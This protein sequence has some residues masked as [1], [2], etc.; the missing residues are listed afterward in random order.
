MSLAKNSTNPLDLPEIRTAVG[1]YLDDPG[2]VQCLQVCRSWYASFLPFVWST[3]LIM[4]DDYNPPIEALSRHSGFVKKLTF[5]SDVWQEYGSI[6]CPHLVSLAIYCGENPAPVIITQYE[7]LR[8]L[9]IYGMSCDPSQFSTFKTTGSLS[10][11]SELELY[12]VNVQPADT[13]DFWNMCMTLETLTIHH[14]SIPEP[15]DRSIAFERLRELRVGIKSGISSKD[16]MNW[17]AQCPNLTSL[18]WSCQDVTASDLIEGLTSR[19]VA[20]AWPKLCELDL[21]DFDASDAQLS[22]II[23]NMQR[24]TVLGVSKCEFGPLSLQALRPH[25]PV[26]R[27]LDIAT[28][29]NQTGP[30]VPEILASCPQLEILFADRVMSQDILEGRPWVCH[31]IET[32]FVSFGITPGRDRDLHQQQVLERLSQLTNL[33]RLCLTCDDDVQDEMNLDLRLEKGLDQLATL[34]KLRKLALYSGNQHM[35]VIDVEV[36]QP[37]PLLFSFLLWTLLVQQVHG[38]N[39]PNR[40]HVNVQVDHQQL[41]QPHR[42]QRGFEPG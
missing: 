38:I 14:A 17:V 16:Q 22:R 27:K 41:D 20:G 18:M 30:M 1:R 6:H 29:P 3:I 33:E 10:N 37:T 25:F 36:N 9:K 2:L 39:A 40:F 5:Q 21:L 19:L 13:A 7:Q 35:S 28:G 32:M 34:K 15:P 42:C 24:V 23:S 31:S 8:S 12:V 11:L 26:L 4:Q